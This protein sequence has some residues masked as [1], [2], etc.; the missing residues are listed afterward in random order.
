MNKYI[1]ILLFSMCICCNKLN[2]QNF[3][4]NTVP[5]ED[6]FLHFN[7]SFF[8]TGE[9]V[10]Y[11]LYCIDKE[12]KKLSAISK[13]AY[14]ELIDKDLKSIFKHKIRLENG[15]GSGDYFIPTNIASGNYKLIAYTQW[16]R[17]WSNNFFE[18]DISI[19]NPFQKN[20]TNILTKNDST[21]KS[22]HTLIDPLKTIPKENSTNNNLTLTVEKNNYH[23]RE[24]IE[25]SVLNANPIINSGNYSISVNK[26]D[27]IIIP[28][29]YSA[30]NYKK[31]FEHSELKTNTFLPELRG[32]LISGKVLNANNEPVQNSKV[33]IAIPGKNFLLKIATTNSE[34]SFYSYLNQSYESDNATFQVLNNENLYISIDR[35]TNLGPNN[36]QFPDFSIKSE[37]RNTILNRSVQNQIENSYASIKLNKEDSIFPIAP[38]YQSK[39]TK[40]YLLDDYT[41]FSSVKETV[42]EIMPEVFIKKHKDNSTFHI[43]ISEDRSNLDILPM[44]IIDGVLVQNHE[45]LLAYN[46]NKI[47]KIH[48][49]GS[50][51]IYGSEIYEGIISVETKNGDYTTSTSGNYIKNVNLFKPLTK[52]QYFQQHYDGNLKFDRIPDYRNILFW[53]PYLTFPKKNNQISFYASDI[54]GYYH[55][56]LEG[57]NEDGSPISLQEIIKVN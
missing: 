25:I 16:M 24:K 37:M 1:Y 6:I 35:I 7:T 5:Q 30:N 34:G 14:V 36:L 44:L 33:A 9:S 55:I 23:L 17:N 12:T 22:N 45:E 18:N 43:I 56:R 47:N 41:R 48:L 42:I 57:F 52:K 2:A 40:T 49:I 28:K 46:P 8:V 11:K 4:N 26:I 31:L 51:Y 54:P 19:V 13:I 29:M 20:L 38:F 15:V 39:I 21:Y 50:Q 10:Y 3:G 32:E 27:S 53:E